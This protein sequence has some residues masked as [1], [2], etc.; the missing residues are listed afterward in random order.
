MNSH[1]N[2]LYRSPRLRKQREKDKEESQKRKDHVSFGTAA[3]TKIGFGLFSLIS[4]STNVVVSQH[5]TE[6]NTTFTQHVM[7]RFHEVNELYDDTLSKVH[8]ILYV[9]DISS[10]KSFTF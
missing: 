4:L 8:H 6:K 5:R 3:A 10:N 2:G 9:T 7:N 1:D